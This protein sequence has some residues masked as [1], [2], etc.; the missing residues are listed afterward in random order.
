MNYKVIPGSE[1]H[2]KL[3]ELKKQIIQAREASFAIMDEVRAE[4]ITES[5]MKLA[6]GISG[7]IFKTP[8]D[9]AVWKRIQ[10]GYSSYGYFPKSI[11]ANKD[12]CKR[13]S[14]LPLVDTKDLR[15]IIGYKFQTYASPGGGIL[16][17]SAPAIHWSIDNQIIIL[18]T[19]N[20]AKYTP[21]D[22]IIEILGSEYEALLNEI[23]EQTQPKQ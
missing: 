18:Q 4:S 14:E 7:F 21:V 19:A 3:L 22:G 8:P 20:Q 1:V 10:T 2:L 5:H 9:T 12:L 6:G 11:K 23:K 15:E 13:I 16:M 17:S